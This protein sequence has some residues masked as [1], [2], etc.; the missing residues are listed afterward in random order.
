M[1]SFVTAL[2]FLLVMQGYR[3]LGETYVSFKFSESSIQ[4]NKGSFPNKNECD[5]A[6][7]GAAVTQE[8][9]CFGG[10]ATVTISATGGTAPY[11]YTFNGVTNSS[12]VFSGVAAGENQAFS[13]SD[14]NLC[15]PVTGSISVTQPPLLELSGAAVTQEILCFG[16]TATVTISATGGTA[17]YS[18]TF[19]GV[20]N[21]SGVFSGVAAG[22]NQA[23]SISDAN[24]CGPV[25]GSISVTQPPLL[26]L[27]GAAVTQ[28]IL[29]F[30]GTATVTIS[31]TGGTAPYSYTFNGVTNSSGVFTGVAAGENQAFSISDA[32]LC[33][34]VT[35]SIS[36]TQP[37]LLELSG[38]AVTQEIL[39]FGGTAT[40]TIS[41]TGGTAPYS[42]T[43][44]GVTNSSGVFSGVA[45]GENQAFSIPMPTFVDPLPDP[46][47]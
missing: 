7:S 33:G 42:Y 11:S 10:T 27:S 40:V 46:S 21:S 20:T 37:P 28:E 15:G 41:A 25:T 1:L 30:G 29:C 14:A 22:E 36:V 44:N 39:C 16:G 9:L 18:Y 8:I 3:S 17:P 23:F 32:N 4:T 5:L 2:L 45:A 13:I 31:A 12:G 35:G 47:V 24:L 19:N 43:F 26:E 38:A 6:L 34:P